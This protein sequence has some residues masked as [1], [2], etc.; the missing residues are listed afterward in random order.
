M[1][2]NKFLSLFFLSG[3]QHSEQSLKF[4]N[5]LTFTLSWPIQLF[6]S[7]HS[8]VSMCNRIGVLTTCSANGHL[9]TFQPYCMLVIISW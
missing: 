9:K 6:F 5:E 7:L 2:P 3:I 1:Y 4:S 8:Q